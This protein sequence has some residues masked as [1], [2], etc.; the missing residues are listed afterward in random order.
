[1]KTKQRDGNKVDDAAKASRQT[2][3]EKD[4]KQLSAKHAKQNGTK[5]PR[6]CQRSENS[7]TGT[8]TNLLTHT[9]GSRKTQETPTERRGINRTKTPI[10]I[11]GPT[12]DT[13]ADTTTTT[14]SHKQWPRP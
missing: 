6:N 1:M 3:Q 7:V 5:I 8:T 2:L 4:S 9:K 12:A 13:T 11:N 14:G 10:Q